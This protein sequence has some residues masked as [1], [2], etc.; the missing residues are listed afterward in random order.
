MR[1]IIDRIA[2]MRGRYWEEATSNTKK[3]L[4]FADKP[5]TLQKQKPC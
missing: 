4:D 2:K 3:N 1:L 5:T